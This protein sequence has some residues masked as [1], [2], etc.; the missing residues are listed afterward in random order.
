M[1]SSR[2]VTRGI[3][4]NDDQ[5]EDLEPSGGNMTQGSHTGFALADQSPLQEANRSTALSRLRGRIQFL[6]LSLL[7]KW[8]LV[9]FKHPII[10]ALFFY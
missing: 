4:L 2:M 5:Y 9:T 10:L 1:N 8:P 3:A 6:C 7:R